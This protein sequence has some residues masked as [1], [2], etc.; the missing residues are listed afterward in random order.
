VIVQDTHIRGEAIVAVGEWNLHR[1]ICENLDANP[2]CAK[3]LG[4]DYRKDRHY[5]RVSGVDRSISAASSQ[6]AMIRYV[7][8]TIDIT[9]IK[10]LVR[11]F[12]YPYR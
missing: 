2:E 3:S 1:G 7:L 5:P 12:V 4:D 10:C 6:M 9:I 8:D 11:R